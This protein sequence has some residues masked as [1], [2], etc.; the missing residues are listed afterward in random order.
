MAEL[1]A[2][3]F[4]AP[5]IA[6]RLYIGTRTVESHLANIYPKLGVTSKQELALK[7]SD[8]GLLRASP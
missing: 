2:R 1:A 5:Q 4:T 8:L 6:E 7:A 3:G